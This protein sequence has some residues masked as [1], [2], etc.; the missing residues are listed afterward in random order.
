MFLGFDPMYWVFLGPTMLLALWAQMRVKSAYGKWSQVEASSRM[1]GAEAAQRMLRSA[2]VGDVKVEAVQGFLSDHY[3]PRSKTLRLSP[4]VYQSNSVAAMGI[5]CHEAG[6]ALQHAQA[7]GPLTFRTAMVPVASIGSML[8]WP[9][10]I[11]GALLNMANLTLL[12]VIAFSAMV[13]FQMVTLPVEFD[14]SNRAKK[15]LQTLGIIQSQKEA[16]GVSAVLDAAA[17][18]Y[19]AATIT[20]VM[21]LL[22]FAMRAGLLGGRRD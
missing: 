11:G 1:S 14:A 10:I 12:G 6:H 19:V 4:G 3:D 21:Q 7:Y 18:T 8:A 2:G 22:Y 5:A 15:Q 17:M 16:G 20:A 13:V 9:M